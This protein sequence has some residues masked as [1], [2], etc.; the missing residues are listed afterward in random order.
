[1]NNILKLGKD[2]CGCTAC[3]QVCPKSC[4]SFGAD[5]EGFLYP[6]VDENLCIECGKCIKHCPILSDVKRGTSPKVFAAKYKDRNT[7]FKSTSGGIFIPLAKFIID[8]GGA[9]F[10]CAFDEA[11]TARHIKIE[12]VDQLYKLQSSKYVQSN[13]EG[14]YSEVKAELD[15]GRYVLFSGTGCQAAGLKNFLD[16]NYDRLITVDIICHGVPSPKLF[17]KY[18]GYMGQKLGNKLTDY[19]FRSKEKRG[20]DL[21]YKATAKNKSKSDYGFFDPYYNAFLTCKTY[22]ESCYNCKFANSQRAGDITLGDYWGIQKMHPE[23]YDDNG[24]SLVLINSDKGQKLWEK[25]SPEIEAVPS[26]L[27]KASVMN[28]NLSSPSARPEC[29][30]TIYD[31]ID[32]NFEEYVKT[33]LAY[34]I[35]YKTKLKKMIPLKLKNKLKALK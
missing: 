13:T 28:K 17:D 16:K 27:E 18:I 12:S 2:C 6:T 7:V 8:K 33:K 5:T 32:G 19:N 29:R 15:K 31:G 30:D 21:Y 24:V 11:L 34:K 26:T 4:I 1:M 14:I 3:E 9:V 23:F 25:I 20:W 22:R 35:N 10:G